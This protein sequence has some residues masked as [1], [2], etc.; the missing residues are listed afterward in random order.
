MK[1]NVNK[2]FKMSKS[3]KLNHIQNHF[4]NEEKKD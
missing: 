1:K 2:T 4:E 3:I